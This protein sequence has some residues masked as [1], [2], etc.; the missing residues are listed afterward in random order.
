[1]GPALAGRKLYPSLFEFAAAMWNKGPIM[2]REMKRRN[3]PVPPLQANEL[4]DIVGYLYSVEYFAGPGDPRRGQE[5]VNAKGCLRCHS[6]RGK[7]GRVGPDFAK[8][9]G[10]DQPANVVSAMWNHGAAM[11]QKIREA[12]LAWPTL[13]ADEMAHIVGFLEALGRSRR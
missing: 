3:V 4:A 9:R 12:T 6:I 5:L 8:I 10:L 13:K 1:V 11:E 7:G 2:T